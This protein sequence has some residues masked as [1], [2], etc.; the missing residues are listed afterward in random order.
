MW[1]ELRERAT[2]KVQKAIDIKNFE[3]KMGKLDREVELSKLYFTNFYED[4]KPLLEVEQI[5]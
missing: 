2:S 4:I 1:S 5:L 3:K